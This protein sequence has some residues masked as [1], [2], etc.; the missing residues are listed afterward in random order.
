VGGLMDGY[1]G[2][3]EGS[4]GVH[5]PLMA[6]VVVLEQGE[7]AV[8][9]RRDAPTRVAIVS[10][11]LLGMHREVTARVRERA[12]AQGI[13]PEGVVLAATH[14]HAGPHGLRGGM[15]SSLNEELATALVEKVSGA[16]AEAALALRPATL[17]LQDW[18]RLYRA[19]RQA[20]EQAAE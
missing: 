9:P 20:T 13:A 18:A 15:F 6:R 5:D 7:G 4:K 16:I 11:D 10:C 17:S 8:L 14:D 1:G 3:F 12:A 19:Y 2:R